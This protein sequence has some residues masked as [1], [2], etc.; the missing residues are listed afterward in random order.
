MQIRGYLHRDIK[1]D[2]ILIMMPSS[3]SEQSANYN[4]SRCYKSKY[5]VCDF[6]FAVKLHEF[7]DKN[8]AGTACYA[9]PKIQSKFKNS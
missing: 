4:Y 1:P 5:K 8:I 3:Q 6:G 2:N 7:S 9:S